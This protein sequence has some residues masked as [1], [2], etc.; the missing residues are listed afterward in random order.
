[1]DKSAGTVP[2][3]DCSSPG[4]LQIIVGDHEVRG[5]TGAKLAHVP[6]LCLARSDVH[7][8]VHLPIDPLLPS[9]GVAVAIIVA[10]VGAGHD[11]ILAFGGNVYLRDGHVHLS[12][13]V[14]V[15]WPRLERVADHDHAGQST[16]NLLLGDLVHVR[17]IPVDPDAVFVG[18]DRDVDIHAIA[19]LELDVNIIPLTQVRRMGTVVVKIGCKDRVG[20]IIISGKIVREME[21]ERVSAVDLQHGSRKAGWV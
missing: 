1:M 13:R 10:A 2:G 19:W 16:L 8:R 6:D 11:L 7:D 20:R 14:L 3:E 9:L 17:V 18:R 4:I 15:L 5:S 12:E 21:L